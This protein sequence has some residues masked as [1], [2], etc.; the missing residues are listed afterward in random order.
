MPIAERGFS[1]T[2]TTRGFTPDCARN[3]SANVG[4]IMRRALLPGRSGALAPL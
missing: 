3:S 2:E 1:E 4:T